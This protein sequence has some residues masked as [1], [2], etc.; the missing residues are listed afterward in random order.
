ME[1]PNMQSVNDFDFLARSFARMEAM[2]LPVDLNALTGNM[3][4][5]LRKWFCHRYVYY[6]KQEFKTMNEVTANL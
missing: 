2:G 1:Q 5:E 4:K 6:C 3:S